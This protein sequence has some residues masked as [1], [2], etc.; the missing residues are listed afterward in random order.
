MIE[1]IHKITVAIRNDISWYCVM[2]LIVLMIVLFF[3]G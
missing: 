1:E 3:W 2:A